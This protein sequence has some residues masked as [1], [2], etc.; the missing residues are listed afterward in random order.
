MKFKKKEIQGLSMEEDLAEF[1]E[2]K[3]AAQSSI[4][5]M[6]VAKPRISL[7]VTADDLGISPERDEG[8]FQAFSDGIITNAS[9]LVNGCSAREAGALSIA[10]VSSFVG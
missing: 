10:L 5:C 2:G 3:A 9:L 7:I 8:I 6:E 4:S 1:R